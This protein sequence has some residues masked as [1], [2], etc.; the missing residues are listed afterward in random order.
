M[1]VAKFMDAAFNQALAAEKL[2]EVPV[3][4]VIVKDGKII[5][6]GHNLREIKQ[7]VLAHAEIV[8]LVKAQ[9]K[10]G[11]WRL[12][13]CELYVTLEPCPMCAA[14]LQQARVKK[15]FYGA[16]DKKGGALSLGFNLNQNSKL[17]HKYEMIYVEQNRCS[18][19]LSR[20]FKFLRKAR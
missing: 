16:T 4:A 2:E 18:K 8:A 20:F 14:A 11:S 9:K 7:S 13:G 5:S 15:V 3:G 19:I 17:N 6:R 10:I 12:E 1:F